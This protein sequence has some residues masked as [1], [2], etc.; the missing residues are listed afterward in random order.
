MQFSQYGKFLIAQ[1]DIWEGKKTMK[2]RFAL[3]FLTILLLILTACSGNVSTPISDEDTVATA[4]A[5]ML[6]GIPTNT[7]LPEPTATLIPEPQTLLPRSL[8]FLAQDTN[9]IGQIFRLS[10]DGTT[11]TQITSEP[12]GVLNLDILQ[13]DGSIVYISQ[14]NLIAVDA[15]GE[16]PQLLAQDSNLGFSLAWSPDGK[17]IAYI[18][19]GVNLYSIETGESRTI[20][21]NENGSLIV[22]EFSPD[23][24]KLIVSINFESA[25]YDVVN[26][27]LFALDNK[28]GFGNLN[29][30]SWL[31]DSKHI[32]IFADIGAGGPQG[33]ISPGLWY[34]NVADGSGG[35]LLPVDGKHCV[36]A[37]KQEADGNLI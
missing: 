34:F 5:T 8:Y 28:A 2:K 27:N 18:S 25:I 31:P 10:R 29:Q 12:N 23:S 35:A 15:N 9:G 13:N 22:R 26:G 1:F 16:N 14:N 33:I 24:S 36:Q 11:I 30:T 4:V 17:Y 20:L 37:P 3:Q 6:S 21:P 7:S 19:E 32:F